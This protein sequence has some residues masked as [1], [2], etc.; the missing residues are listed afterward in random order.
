MPQIAH[1][2]RHG[3]HMS[4]VGISSSTS[5][6]NNIF[7]Q[8]MLKSIKEQPAGASMS[9]KALNQSTLRSVMSFYHGPLQNEASVFAVKVIAGRIIWDTL[10]DLHEL[11]T[12]SEGWNSYGACAPKHEAVIN[13]ANWIF[14]L[15]LEVLDL[16]ENWISPNVTAS[17]DGEV[18]FGW[19]HDSK[20]LTIYIGEKT[21]EYVQAWGPDIN[22]DMDDGDADL[23]STR[24]LLWKW[25]VS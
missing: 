9:Y 6:A 24:Q 15:F 2:Q 13:A 1:S 25:L 17:A 7:Y 8:D 16:D 19:R 23:T 3:T 21:A 12:W 10:I 20:R 4:G 5:Q 11:L 18:V 22:K 14:Q